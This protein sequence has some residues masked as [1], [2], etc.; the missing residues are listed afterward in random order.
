MTV[1]REVGEAHMIYDFTKLRPYVDRDHIY[2]I[3]HSLGGVI[4]TLISSE[5]RPRAI[6][7]LTP[8]SDMNNIDF[9]KIAAV[10]QFE[11][12]EVLTIKDLISKAH[13]MEDMD[14]GGEKLSNK[15]WIDFIGKDT[16]GAAS[17]IDRLR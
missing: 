11:G 4:S 13:E 14:I 9:L 2:V 10:S 7:L 12:D 15:F 8:A 3:D 6:A 5:V 16:Y 17:Q 1:S